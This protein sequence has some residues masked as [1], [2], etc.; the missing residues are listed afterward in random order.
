MLPFPH[1]YDWCR[2]IKNNHFTNGQANLFSSAA[3]S[4]GDTAELRMPLGRVPGSNDDL[5]LLSGTRARFSPAPGAQTPSSHLP[6][7]C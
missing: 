6:G 7:C 1:E 4:E 3:D 2:S 5:L